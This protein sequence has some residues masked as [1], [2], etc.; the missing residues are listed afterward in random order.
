M[1]GT[2]MMSNSPWQTL[3]EQRDAAIFLIFFGFMFLILAMTI[4]AATW[5]KIV[6]TRADAELKQSMIERGMSF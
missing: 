2:M 1:P 5:Q 6:R 3:L 4:G